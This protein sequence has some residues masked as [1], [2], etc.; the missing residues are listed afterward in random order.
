MKKLLA[1]ITMLVLLVTLSTAVF[2]TGLQNVS[3][4]MLEGNRWSDPVDCLGLHAKAFTSAPYIGMCNKKV[5]TNTITNH[6][7][8]SQWIS[9]AFTGTRWDWQI[10]KPGTFSANCISFVIQSNDDVNVAFDGFADL[11]PLV[12]TDAPAIPVWYN[13]GNFGGGKPPVDGWI[14]ATDLNDADFTFSYDQIKNGFTAKL[15][16]KIQID[17]TTRADDYED[18]GTITI[19]LTDVKYFIDPETG[20]FNRALPS[21]NPLKL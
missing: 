15:W 3:V 5:C 19:T 4:W 7:T 8:V 16:N 20:L 10:R 11:A 13:Y 2:A 18:S 9:Y 21:A 14:R 17:P 1:V 6:C 12:H